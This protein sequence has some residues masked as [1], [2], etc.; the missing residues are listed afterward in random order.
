MIELPDFSPAA[1][2]RS[3]PVTILGQNGRRVKG[4]RAPPL[5]KPP[6]PRGL[7]MFGFLG[8]F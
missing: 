4:L 3:Q 7:E 1:S 8:D 6:K 2:R 5:P